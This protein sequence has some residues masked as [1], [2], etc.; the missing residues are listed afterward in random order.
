MIFTFIN[1]VPKRLIISNY[2]LKSWLMNSHNDGIPR[3]I[4]FNQITYKSK[5]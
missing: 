1:K 3:L 2:G 5:Y 4:C